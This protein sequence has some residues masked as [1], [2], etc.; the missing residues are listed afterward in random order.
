MSFR[1]GPSDPALGLR[2]LTEFRTL[3]RQRTSTGL[4]PLEYQRWLDLEQQLASRV[5]GKIRPDGRTKLIAEFRD[6]GRLTESVMPELPRGGFFVSTPFA[7]PIGTELDLVVRVQATG[8]EIEVPVSVV[9]NNVAG[10]FST[11]RLGMAVGFA[12]L[13]A[14]Q[15]SWAQEIGALNGS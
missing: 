7:A 13:D 11:Q 12:R 5:N 10:G 4:T 1:A 6:D 15:L 14:K 2:L 8:F 9:S 3:E